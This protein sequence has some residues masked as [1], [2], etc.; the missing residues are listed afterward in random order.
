M[1]VGCA[2]HAW[3]VRDARAQ[4]ARGG[5]SAQGAQGRAGW[6]PGQGGG[7]LGEATTGAW[8]RPRQ[9]ATWVRR[10]PRWRGGVGRAVAWA[11]RRPG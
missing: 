11:R 1:H 10:R 7:G 2:G 3:G 4:G 8:R 6:W 5:Q 9:T